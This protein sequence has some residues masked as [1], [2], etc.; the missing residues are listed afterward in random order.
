MVCT[1]RTVTTYAGPATLVLEDG[2]QFTVKVALHSSDLLGRHRWWGFFGAAHAPRAWQAGVGGP[3]TLR[4][5]DGQEGRVTP[6]RSDA[7]G[8]RVLQLTGSGPAPF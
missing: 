6:E 4:L 7:L 3:A 1:L 2:S 8:G 5:P